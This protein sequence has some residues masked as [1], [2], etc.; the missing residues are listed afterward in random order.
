MENVYSLGVNEVSE[1]RSAG[2]V[3]LPINLSS[4]TSLSCEEF[5]RTLIC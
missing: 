1:E 4:F 3:L 5:I 2:R